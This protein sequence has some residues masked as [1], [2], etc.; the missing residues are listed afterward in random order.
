MFA[1]REMWP[2]KF[3]RKPS[4]F[5][6]FFSLK[7]ACPRNW[8]LRED[9]DISENMYLMYMNE[10]CDQLDSC[11]TGDPLPRPAPARQRSLCSGARAHLLLATLTVV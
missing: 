8:E 7:T 6:P 4:S 2:K 10:G 5:L 9:Q 3:E 11:S 1:K